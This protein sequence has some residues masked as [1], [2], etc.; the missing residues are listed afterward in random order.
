M[1]NGEYNHFS[2]VRK[3]V[4]NGVI[5]VPEDIAKEIKKV[6]V[7]LAPKDTGHLADS[8]NIGIE[9]GNLTAIQVVAQTHPL[10]APEVPFST[11]RQYAYYVE[12]GTVHNRY[13]N[14]VHP[15]QPFM[16]PAAE[17]GR[18]QMGVSTGEWA[19]RIETAAET[20]RTQR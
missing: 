10:N 8:I 18:T 12:Y 5:R 11:Q 17:A 7:E 4:E 1:N 19:S 14:P 6:A 15:P 2:A 9:P 20:G 16:T 13:G 3:T